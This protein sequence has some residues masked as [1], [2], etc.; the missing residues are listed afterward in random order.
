MSIKEGELA[1]DV[2]G[3]IDDALD[4]IDSVIKSHD[5]G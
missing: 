2:A 1:E 3:D 5:R 4:I